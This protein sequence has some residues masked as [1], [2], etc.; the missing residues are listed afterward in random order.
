M[1]DDK[2]QEDEYKQ[3]A[4]RYRWLRDKGFWPV[5]IETSRGKDLDATIDFELR[6]K[7]KAA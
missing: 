5:L 6:R 2:K 3:D 1:N 4:L 7:E